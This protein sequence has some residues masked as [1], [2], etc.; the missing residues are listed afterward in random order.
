MDE[1]FELV[2]TAQTTGGANITGPQDRMT[3]TIGDSCPAPTGIF[4]ERSSYDVSEGA[5]TLNVRAVRTGDLTTPQN[6]TITTTPVTAAKPGDYDHAAF[7]NRPWPSGASF[8]DFPITIVNDGQPEINEKF[9]VTL[10]AGSL[11]SRPRRRRSRSSITILRH[12]R[13]SAEATRRLSP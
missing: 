13:R 6:V 8:V 4:F 7:S 11:T 9:T 2:M 3:V 5:G 12:R 1:T 10:S